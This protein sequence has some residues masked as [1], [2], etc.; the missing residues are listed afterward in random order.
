M[1][2]TERWP[3]RTKSLPS[4]TIGGQVRIQ[5]D[6]GHCPTK[7]H[8]TG[9]VLEVCQFHQYVEKADGSDR[10][11]LCNKNF[12]VQSMTDLVMRST[13]EFSNPG[14]LPSPSFSLCMND[15]QCSLGHHK[16]PPPARAT[17]NT[18][19]PPPPPPLS[20]TSLQ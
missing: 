13:A 17:V 20:P 14:W 3:E 9:A 2:V 11:T 18:P 4:L 12:L 6:T 1:Q 19:P 16:H 15:T 10:M 5:N 8:K 7:W